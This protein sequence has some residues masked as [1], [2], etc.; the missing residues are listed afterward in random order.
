MTREEFKKVFK[1]EDTNWEG[2]NAYQGLQ[3]LSKY[4]DSLIK[5][6]DH[7][8]IYSCD[9]DYLIEKGITKEDAEKLRKLNWMIYDGEYMACFV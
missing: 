4:A 6:A 9:V 5:G 8:I 2:D 1:N 3:I 7:D